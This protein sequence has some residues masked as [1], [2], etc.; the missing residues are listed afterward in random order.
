MSLYPW[1]LKFNTEARNN[2]ILKGYYDIKMEHSG[3]QENYFVFECKLMDGTNDKIKKYIHTPPTKDK[4]E[5]GGLFR[6]LI[7]KYATDKNTGG[8]L[9]YVIKSDIETII[10]KTK[11]EISIYKN[12]KNDIEF[13]AL[14]SSG[15]LNQKSYEMPHSFITEHTKYDLIKECLCEHPIKIHH[16]FLNF[17]A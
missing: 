11:N 9:G 8:M 10:T 14:T 6:F 15:L 4:K 1:D 17:V 16:I 7:N 12:K 5:D 3:W 2:S 13:G